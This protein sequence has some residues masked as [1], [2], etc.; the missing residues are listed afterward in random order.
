MFGKRKESQDSSDKQVFNLRLFGKVAPDE[1]AMV[2]CTPESLLESQEMTKRR[3]FLTGRLTLPPNRRSSASQPSPVM[4]AVQAVLR[5]NRFDQDKM[6][7]VTREPIAFYIDSVGGDEM[8]CFPLVSA[9]RL[10]KTPVHT[11]NL[12]EWRNASL[13]IGIVGSTRFT[14][15]DTRFIL[16]RPELEGANAMLTDMAF[17][18]SVSETASLVPAESVAAREFRQRFIKET[19]HSLLLNYTSLTEREF[20]AMMSEG[21]YLTA[22]EAL[23]FGLVDE[24]VEDLEVIL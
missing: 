9:V 8:E 21:L 16:T 11:I 6:H 5:F 22:E 10:S 2:Q 19:I 1:V 13:Y 15:P 12:G 17:Y 20:E 23:K 7:S 24:I 14:L 4:R 18:G 3:L